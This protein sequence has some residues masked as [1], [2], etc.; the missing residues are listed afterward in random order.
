M[1]ET[2][3][4]EKT[5]DKGEMKKRYAQNDADNQMHECEMSVNRDY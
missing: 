1:E 3:Y 5:M 4:E 2:K